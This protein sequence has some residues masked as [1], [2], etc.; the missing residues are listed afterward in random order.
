MTTEEL[1][2]DAEDGFYI[3]RDVIDGLHV[4]SYYVS[5]PHSNISYRNNGSLFGESIILLFEELY[6]IDCHRSKKHC[7]C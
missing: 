6:C 3:H 4:I 1:I 7:L 5:K 2:R